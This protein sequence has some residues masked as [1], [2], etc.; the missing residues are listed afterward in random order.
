MTDAKSGAPSPERLD[1]LPGMVGMP[2]PHRADELLLAGRAA[3]LN[4]RGARAK[5]SAENKAARMLAFV[6]SNLDRLAAAGD[7]PA[8][9]AGRKDEK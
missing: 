4:W 9:W 6:F 5:S 3:L 7:L 2:D 1:G 8:D